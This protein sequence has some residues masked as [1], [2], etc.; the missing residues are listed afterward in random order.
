[1]SEARKIT[2]SYRIRQLDQIHSFAPMSQAEAQAKS[3][4]LLIEFIR[5]GSQ[6]SA[7]KQSK[8]SRGFDHFFGLAS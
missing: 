7:I 6:S 4:P 5:S 3:E 1:M 2:N 8:M